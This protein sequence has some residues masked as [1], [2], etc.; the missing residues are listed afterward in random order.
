MLGEQPSHILS[1]VL[2]GATGGPTNAQHKIINIWPSGLGWV[3][4]G[5]NTSCI[6]HVDCP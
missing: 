5:P 6:F 1:L 4:R 2:H 3:L